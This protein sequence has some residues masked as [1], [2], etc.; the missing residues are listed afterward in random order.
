MQTPALLLSWLQNAPAPLDG[1]ATFL[2]AL[3]WVHFVAG[4]MWIGL[5]YFFNVVNVSFMRDLDPA[6]RG[7]VLPPL[8][9]RALW[10]FRWSSVVAVLAGIAY[11]MTIVSADARNA[12]TSGGHAIW[13]FFVIWTLAFAIENALVMPL[14]GPLNNGFV[15]GVL[16]AVVMA[17]ASYLYLDLN[18]HGWESNRLLAIGIGGGMGW[19]LLLNV[20]GI[21]WRI[22]KRIIQWTREDAAH[23]TPIPEKAQR[24]ARQAFLVSRISA[25]LTIPLLFFMGAA[26]H[27]PFLGR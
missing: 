7:K 5:L 8:L 1:N 18:S 22:N 15:L 4:I 24:L 20:W 2:M 9:S 23:G 13:T 12:Q 3:R 6:T 10:W 14:K 27:Y 16:V 17:T 19:F 21:V 25:W 26:S 11:W